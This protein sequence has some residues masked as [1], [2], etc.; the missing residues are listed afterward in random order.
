MPTQSHLEQL[1]Q[2]R[3][4]S[5]RPARAHRAIMDEASSILRSV[6]TIMRSYADSHHPASIGILLSLERLMMVLRGKLQ[7]LWAEEH[8]HRCAEGRIWREIC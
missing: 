4:R 6:P 8:L 1:S 3:L 2:L 7:C 5:T